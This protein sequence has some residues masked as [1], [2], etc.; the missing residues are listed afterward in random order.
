MGFPKG[1][2][3]ARRIGVRRSLCMSNLRFKC[4][5]SLSASNT[6][7]LA[8]EAW[9]WSSTRHLPMW[10]CARQGGADA[11]PPGA[12]AALVLAHEKELI[13]SSMSFPKGYPCAVGSEPKRSG[14][15]RRQSDAPCSQASL[16]WRVWRVFPET[17]RNQ[18]HSHLSTYA[19]RD[20]HVPDS[21]S[22]PKARHHPSMG[23]RPMKPPQ[24]IHRQ[25]GR[26]PSIPDLPGRIP[27]VPHEIRNRIR[28]TICLGLSESR[29]TIPYSRFLC[30]RRGCFVI[31]RLFEF[32]KI[33]SHGHQ[34]VHLRV[35]LDQQ[36]PKASC[37]SSACCPALRTCGG[38]VVRRGC[39]KGEWWF[40][41]AKS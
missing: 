25:S 15:S 4:M 27:R 40:L 28:R 16:D 14:D 8:H 41:A 24:Q 18:R 29:R 20:T 6:Q 26:A 37:H 12:W 17:K 9:T 38:R 2:P 13:R 3:C 32:N 21:I 7:T 1:F 31:H 11:D 22:A 23:Q 5:V 36:A 35:V 39:Y 10:H 19:V 34:N 30:L 33:L